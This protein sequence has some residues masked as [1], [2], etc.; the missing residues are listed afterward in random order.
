VKEELSRRIVCEVLQDKNNLYQKG[1]TR[2]WC[3]IIFC[4]RQP[5]FT[6]CFILADFTI[7]QDKLE[8]VFVRYISLITNWSLG[9]LLRLFIY[10]PKV[11]H[12]I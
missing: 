11:C 9:L 12:L 3:Q 5:F 6:Y 10:I 1:R 2:T 4:L 7:G 8:K